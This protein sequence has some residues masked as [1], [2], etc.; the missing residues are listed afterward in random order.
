M[1][2][3]EINILIACEES[4]EVANAFRS[5]GFNAFSCDLQP[6]SGGH[7]E[8]HIQGDAIAEAYS[9]K[10]EMMIAHPPCTY[11]TNS[12]V[13]WLNIIDGKI[14]NGERKQDMLWGRRFFMDLLNAPI[15]YKAI[16]NPVSHKHAA[17]PPYSQIIQPWQFGHKKMKA[18]CLWLS[19]LPLLT[20]TDTVG[21]P[22]KDKVLKY[23]WQDVWMA[24]PGPERAKLRSKTYP[25]I[26][27]AIAKQYGD[28]LLKNL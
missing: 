23:G 19:G 4:Q 26:A 28:F 24:S 22:P 12:G 18:T 15:K 11:L 16:E 5:L 25:G 14:T 20:P 1:N 8:Y 3:S 6:C 21:P 2:I 17:L 9:G 10:Y 7:P 13:R 27:K